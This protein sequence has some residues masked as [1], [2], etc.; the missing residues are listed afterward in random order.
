MTG[1]TRAVTARRHQPCGDDLELPAGDDRGQIFSAGLVLPPDSPLLPMSAHL[2]R[3]DLAA[4]GDVAASVDQ[5]YIAWVM[6][7]YR[8][9]DTPIAPDDE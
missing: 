8:S 1:D 5:F 4:S 2:T 6:L 9:L 7:T 3:R